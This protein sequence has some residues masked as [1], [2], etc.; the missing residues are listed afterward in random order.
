[1]TNK[2]SSKLSETV[3]LVFFNNGK[4]HINASSIIK[5]GLL[6][7]KTL[8]DKILFQKILSN[9]NYEGILI[10]QEVTSLKVIVISD[11]LNF[12]KTI[13]IK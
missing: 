6:T 11:E 9:T 2:D 12:Q 13:K 7:V 10:P 8:D 5:Q 4:I 1:M 3:L